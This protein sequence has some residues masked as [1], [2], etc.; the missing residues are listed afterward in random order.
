M[1]NPETGK[2]EPYIETWRRFTLKPGAEVLLLESV[3]GDKAFL[4]RVDEWA[5]GL[6]KTA[7]SFLAWRDKLDNAGW[8]RQTQIGLD[9]REGVLPALPLD[10]AHRDEWSRSSVVELGGRKW[11]V[12]ENFVMP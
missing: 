7:D 9:G 1:F 12:L 11:V 5:L 2:D 10:V 6:S 3:S 8:T 4:G